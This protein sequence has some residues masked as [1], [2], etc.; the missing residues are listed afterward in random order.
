MK[1]PPSLLEVYNRLDDPLPVQL[2]GLTPKIEA[3][4]EDIL[5]EDAPEGMSS[6][7]YEFQ[8]VCHS[9]TA[10]TLSLKKDARIQHCLWKLASRELAPQRQ[11]DLS[12]RMLKSIECILRPYYIDSSM[13]VWNS[14][15]TYPEP[16][17]AI[18]SEGMGTG[19]TCICL[20]LILTSRQQLAKIDH[21]SEG[22]GPSH[23][24]TVRTRRHER[25]P[26]CQDENGSEAKEYQ[27]VNPWREN[28]FEARRSKS[29][30]PSLHSLSLDLLFC[31]RS[32]RDLAPR[33]QDQY[34]PTDDDLPYVWEIP[35]T[36][37]R[38]ATRSTAQE[39]KKWY[40]SAATLVIVP[41]ILIAQWLGEI[42]KHVKEDALDYIK[43][44]KNDKMPG[45]AQL[46]QLDLVLVSEGKVR[47][48]AEGVKGWMKGD[49]FPLD[50][51]NLLILVPIVLAPCS[52]PYI[53]NT[54]KTSC[55][56]SSFARTSYTV[57]KITGN[58][59]ASWQKGKIRLSLVLTG[60]V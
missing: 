19:K 32:Q 16:K 27:P 44:E 22:I 57:T 26:W 29:K 45:A 9:L 40:I 46:C 54:R 20:A 21:E 10:T 36:K 33:M 11:V 30:I 60:G 41:D 6:R 2:E 58:S 5:E 38:E 51:S 15:P 50:F 24:S 1:Y 56:V 28:T 17:S 47:A 49:C 37:G 55:K 13:L 31:S 53:G 18:I 14:A 39:K 35:P 7:L 8:K 4:L 48:E 23:M 3:R 42:Q 43:V 34:A 59:V 25:F 52:C 12:Y